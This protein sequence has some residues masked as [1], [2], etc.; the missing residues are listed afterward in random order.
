M[1]DA[2]LNT[3]VLE[4]LRTTPLGRVNHSEAHAVFARVAELGYAITAPATA[5]R[6]RPDTP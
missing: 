3:L 2:D 6:E 4:L 5:I 1:T